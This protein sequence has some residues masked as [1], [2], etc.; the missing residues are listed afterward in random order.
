MTQ[1]EEAA[2][3][4]DGV[5]RLAILDRS[6]GD[7]FGK[8]MAAAARSFLAYALALPAIALIVAYQIVAAESETPE[9]MTGAVIIATVIELVGVPV[10]LAP[11]LTAYGRRERWAW[12]VTG[13]NWFNAARFALFLAVLGLCFGP[14]NGLGVWPLRVVIVYCYVIEAFMAEAM[15]DIGGLK[16]GGIVLLDALFNFGID[17]VANWIGTGSF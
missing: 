4:I 8:D 1:L 12:F 5:G 14:L 9:V 11:L 15:L 7:G 6:G 17:G 13:Y 2:R 10:L 3:A 16:A